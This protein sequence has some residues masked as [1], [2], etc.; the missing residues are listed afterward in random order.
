M[1]TNRGVT[2]T[3]SILDR[4]VADGRPLVERARQ[5]EPEPGLI[6]RFNDYDE[7]WGMSRAIATPRGLAPAAPAMQ[8]IAE[9]KKASPSKGVLAEEMD[10]E[11]IARSYTLG[12]A[13]GISILTEPN[14]FLGSLEYLRNARQVLGREFPGSRPS[15][16]RKDFLVEPYQVMQA[17]AYGADTIL[18]IVAMLDA[19]LLGEML[20]TARDAGVDAL[21]EVH[22]EAEAERA[23]EAGATLF[24]INNRDLHT[25]NVDLA[26]TER[27][28]P[29]LPADAIVV[30]ESGV[31]NRADA[32]RL[33][34][35]GVQAILV[36]EA[37]MTAPDITAKMAELR[38]EPAE[39]L[40]P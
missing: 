2:Q 26:V 7:Q 16:L 18:L 3:G 27:I 39:G 4:I 40:R 19:A 12:G 17:R 9:I 8:I 11:A 30:G 32:G 34:R 31:Q 20:A 22:T 1:T 35:A 21:V 10:P 25:F 15:L 5:D 6:A 23:V 14:Y 38:P 29:L 37:F 13:A 28:R 36:G 33:Q 24:G